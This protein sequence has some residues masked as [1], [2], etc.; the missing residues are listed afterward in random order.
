MDRRFDV[1]QQFLKRLPGEF[2]IERIRAELQVIVPGYGPVRGDVHFL[3]VARLVPGGEHAPAGQVTLSGGPVRVPKPDP[4]AIPGFNLSG[5]NHC[6]PS[7]IF[8]PKPQPLQV[9][10][11]RHVRPGSFNLLLPPLGDELGHLLRQRFLPSSTW[12]PAPTWQPG[13]MTGPLWRISSR[14]ALLQKPGTSG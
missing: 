13:A 14:E 5:T 3:E 10:R 7:G 9:I 1:G 4:L 6:F 2:H 12:A 8:P 11:K